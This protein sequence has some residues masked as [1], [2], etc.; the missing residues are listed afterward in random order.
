LRDKVVKMDWQILLG[1]GGL[2][3]GIAGIIVAIPNSLLAWRKLRNPDHD[4]I[5]FPEPKR[6]TLG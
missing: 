3:I 6:T 5:Q 1:I 2:L 4:H